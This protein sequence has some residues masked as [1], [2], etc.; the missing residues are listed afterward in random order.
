MNYEFKR[1]LISK[2]LSEAESHKLIQKT[3]MNYRLSKSEAANLIIKNK[4]DI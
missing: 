4:I 2:G 3:A 1:I